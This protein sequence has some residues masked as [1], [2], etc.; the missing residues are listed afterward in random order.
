MI[1]FE[2]P[3]SALLMMIAAMLLAC[4]EAESQVGGDDG[5]QEVRVPF[6]TRGWKTDFAK[7][8]VPLNEIISGGPPKDGI[9]AVDHPSFVSVSEADR[10]MEDREPIIV[11][12]HDGAVRGYPWQILI[13]HEIVNDEVRGLPVT[14]TY[15]PLCNTA[16]AFDRRVGDK[17]LDFGTTGRLRHSD[18]VMYDRQT[19][20][21][22][23][24]AVGEAIVGELTGTMLTMLPA[25]TVSWADF[26]QGYPDADVLS[27][28]TGIS[29]SYGGSPY[30]GYD[31]GE[32][33][34]FRGPTDGRLPMMARVVVVKVGD[35]AVVYPME[36]LADE[37]VINHDVAG[38]PVALFYRKGT[39]S[40]VDARSIADGREVGSAE[41][42]LRRVEG[43]TLT[44]RPH[45]DG[46]KDEETGTRWSFFGQALEGPLAGTR[47]EQAVSFIPFW[48][49]WAAFSPE[50][51]I[52]GL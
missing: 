41:V 29:R 18:L 6:G 45:G 24:Q 37:T 17:V 7:H 16:I 35:D 38:S 52:Y 5:R 48:F 46:F 23:Q 27:R 42:F 33:F 51:P 10:W 26:K 4:G 19:E 30:A 32:P 14:V 50:T 36:T 21:W 25:P 3:S 9:P 43:Q 12:E 44:F 28:D 11:F 1:S 2:R 22:W 8:S 13:W 20:S 49:A 34:L 47:L 40:A 15:C 39:A 31:T